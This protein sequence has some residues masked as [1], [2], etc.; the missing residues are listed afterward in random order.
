ME[1]HMGKTHHVNVR[2]PNNNQIKYC[3][4]LLTYTLRIIGHRLNRNGIFLTCECCVYLR[5]PFGVPSCG[6]SPTSC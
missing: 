6:A 4:T 3:L 5:G 2:T 1:F